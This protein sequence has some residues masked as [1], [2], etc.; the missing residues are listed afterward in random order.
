MSASMIHIGPDSAQ[1]AAS[2]PTMTEALVRILDTS[3]GD[4]EKIAA[5]QALG[6]GFKAG[7]VTVSDCYFTNRAPEP[8]KPEA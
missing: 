6:S 1:L 5:I 8:E 3:A 7:Q 4:A 2:L